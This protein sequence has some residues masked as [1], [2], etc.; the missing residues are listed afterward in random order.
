MASEKHEDGVVSFA[1]PAEVEDWIES[2]ADHRDESRSAICRQLLTAARAVVTDEEL[3]GPADEADVDDLRAQLDAQREE[4][5]ALVEDVRD[6]VVQVKREADAKAPADHDHEAY[7]TD[8]DVERIDADL[9]AL[10]DELAGL[11]DRVDGG[12]DNFES[13]L[14]HLLDETDLLTDRSIA[15]ANAIIELREQRASLAARERR[16]AA[17]DALKLAASRSNVRSADCGDCGT[18][19]DVALLTRP[20]CP[21]CA[22][23][24]ADVER[25]GSILGSHTLVVGEP[26]ALPGPP[27]DAENP[28]PVEEIAAADAE[29]RSPDENGGRQ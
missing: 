4:F 23:S 13:I 1:L 27:V 22:A 24:I 26:P 18:S 3:G 6:R 15:L 17:A 10:A 11:A 5:V 20:E 12:F 7:A 14:D 25:R 16:R 29:E 28:E 9:D 21:H 2:Q 8:E 19:V